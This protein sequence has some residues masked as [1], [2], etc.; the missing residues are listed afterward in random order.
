ML[1]LVDTTLVH[2]SPPEAHLLE[3]LLDVTDSSMTYRR[4]YQDHLQPAP[5]LDLLLAD[6]TNPRSLAFQLNTLANEVD[7][8]PRNTPH[9]GC[10][11][12][13]RL[14][15]PALTAL[16]LASPHELAAVTDG[17]RVHLSELLGR[18]RTALVGLSDSLTLTYL[19]HLQIS[20]HLSSSRI[21]KAEG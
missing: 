1:T 11:A 4:R 19:S 10:T 5:V 20:R 12:E 7:H 9:P 2:V 21:P 18:L 17:K 16:R 6:E 13:Q 15:L 3:A 8:L 14:M